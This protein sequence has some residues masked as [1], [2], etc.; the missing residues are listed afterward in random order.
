M[1][2]ICIHTVVG[3]LQM[4]DDDDDDIDYN[5]WNYTQSKQC[6]RHQ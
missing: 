3:A 6:L 5:I 2:C 4:L 1:A